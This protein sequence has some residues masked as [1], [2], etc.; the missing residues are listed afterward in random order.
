MPPGSKLNPTAPE[1]NY[2]ARPRRDAAAAGPVCVQQIAEQSEQETA[3]TLGHCYLST[4]ERT[5][6]Y[7]CVIFIAVFLVSFIALCPVQEDVRGEFA[8]IRNH[9]KPTVSS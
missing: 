9:K 8:N 5:N 1:F 6:I 4:R 2:N 7:P 3:L